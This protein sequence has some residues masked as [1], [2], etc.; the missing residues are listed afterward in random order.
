MTA[1]F[2]RIDLNAFTLPGF[3]IAKLGD[4]FQ[5]H[6]NETTGELIPNCCTFH[7]NIFE[8][9]KAWYEKEENSYERI[10]QSDS[11]IWIEEIGYLSL[12]E[13]IVK[14]I[15]MTEYVILKR[16]DNPDWYNAITEFIQAN[17]ESF[18]HPAYGLNFYLTILENLFANNQF[19]LPEE[20][21]QR[22]ID[23]MNL[24]LKPSEADNADDDDLEILNSIY[25]QWLNYFPFSLSFFASLKPKYEKRLPIFKTATRNRYTGN[26]YFVTHT[27]KSLY[28]ILINLTNS[29]LTE[30]L[31]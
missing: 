2:H 6:K 22:L 29:L 10:S 18:G 30:S 21:Q 5:G 24:W 14:Q 31:L 13:K 26:T 20:K 8:Q 7:K 12:P 28:E 25:Q 11:N 1:K 4:G 23:Y 9:L 3:E 16:K 27:R 15:S 19:D 17:V